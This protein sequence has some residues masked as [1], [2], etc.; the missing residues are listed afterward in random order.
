MNSKSVIPCAA[1]KQ[2]TTIA[3]STRVNHWVFTFKDPSSFDYKRLE[4]LGQGKSCAHL[5]YGRKRGNGSG[6]VLNGVVS[7]WARKKLTQV[8]L[9][10]GYAA[11]LAVVEERFVSKAVDYCKE[12]GEYTEHCNRGYTEPKIQSLFPA[13]N[14]VNVSKK[15]PDHGWHSAVVALAMEQP[16]RRKITFIVDGTNNGGTPWVMSQVMDLFRD[17]TQVLKAGPKC[18]IVH[19]VDVT[20]DI[21]LVEVPAGHTV[22]Y[23]ALE[24]M[25]NGILFSP[26]FEFGYKVIMSPATLV[27]AF[28]TQD[29]DPKLIDEEKYNSIH[30]D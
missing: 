11:K 25:R 8:K 13:V 17:R 2:A 5:V 10:V 24:M 21:F 30:V 14:V 27:V 20:K 6:K 7:F 29:P 16:I 1:K 15:M 12:G 23:R 4:S 19:A 9:L 26:D 3:P 18:D 28:V 22:D